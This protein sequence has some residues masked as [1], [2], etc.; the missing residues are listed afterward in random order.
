MKGP[1]DKPKAKR[2]KL[3]LRA[4]VIT[5]EELLKELERKKRAKEEN[6][7]RKAERME[8]RKNL[9]EK[10]N[11][12]TKKKQAKKEESEEEEE[13]EESEE[14]KVE[15]SETCTES[16]DESCTGENESDV[17]QVACW[18]ALKPP[19]TE[20]E[21]IGKFFAC[22]YP[23]KKGPNLYVGRLTRRFLSNDEDG[24]PCALEI[25]CL[26]QK[27]G[28]TDCIF[29]EYDIAGADVEVFPI[30]NIVCGPLKCSFLGSKKWN[31]PQYK[32]FRQLFE[33]VKKDDREASHKNYLC[34]VFYTKGKE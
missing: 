1:V 27:Y 3:D 19:T 18:E 24:Y 22:I 12:L 23:T 6:E 33:K 4:K 11:N 31:F 17:T 21:L 29:K 16:S 15:E 25:D 10:K 9:N 14:E 28:V 20:K 5:Q 26:Q 2:M 32:E 7:M 13:D 30:H 34:K 8:K